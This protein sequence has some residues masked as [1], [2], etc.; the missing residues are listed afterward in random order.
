M[1][2]IRKPKK[3]SV[4]QLIIWNSVFSYQIFHKIPSEDEVK[5]EI[6]GSIVSQTKIITKFL[7]QG[8]FFCVYFEYGSIYPRTP[9]V[10]NTTIQA[11]K[12]NPRWEDEFER[13]EQTFFIIDSTTQNIY[14]SNFSKKHLIENFLQNYLPGE[15]IVIKNIIDKENFLTTL[16]E[17]KTI[18]IAAQPT[19]FTSNGILWWVLTN[20]IHN[21]GDEVESVELKINYK[22]IREL[23]RPQRGLVKEFL[24]RLIREDE[25]H[26]VTKLQVVGR[27]D[28]SFE[29]IF[30]A[31]WIVD[32]LRVTVPTEE[33]WLFNPDN[34]FNNVISKI[35]EQE[36]D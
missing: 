4:C 2:P 8:R 20:D 7:Q 32:K 5:E 10:Y 9:E 27:S 6:N 18:S 19:L 12:E 23:W 29:R 22:G 26:S 14:I 34:I 16:E 1:D 28:T 17:A 36:W 3:F 21:F 35:Y 31:E 25:D 15:T 11:D 30:N 33:N 24:R 13:N